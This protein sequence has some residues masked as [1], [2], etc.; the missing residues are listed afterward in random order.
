MVAFLL[1]MMMVS[2]LAD[3]SG[4]LESGQSASVKVPAGDTERVVSVLVSVDAPSTLKAGAVEVRLTMGDQTLSKTL[5]VGDPDVAW[6]VRQPKGEAGEVRLEAEKGLGESV[7]YV[8]KA[9]DVGP[10]AEDG[11][12]FESEPNDSPETADRLT[13]GQ[14]V[15]GLADD[16]AYLPR[17]ETPTEAEKTAG[18]DWYRLDFQGEK[19]ALVY[20]GLEYVDRDV[21]PDVRIF[22]LKDGKP[23]EYTEGIDPQSL[24][25]E[26]P[27]RPGANKFTTRV[28]KKDT[29]Y[30]LVDACQPDYQLRTWTYPVPPYLEK[31]QEG[32]EEV[33]KA[34]RLAIRSA[35]DFQVA[36]GDSWHANTP[37]QG[38]PM[39]RVANPHQ[40]TSTC[41]GCH[42]T[43]F[44]TQSS[45]EAVANGYK[46]GQ[47]FAFRFL[48]DRL[49]NN[50]VP[51]SGHSEAL[52]ARM[53]PAP[54]NVMGRLSTIVMDGENLITGA[55]TRH[56]NMHRGVAEFLGMY[57]N[58]RTTIPPDE[59]NGNNPV[60]RY[61]VASDAWKQLEEIHRRTNEAR[62]AQTRDVVANLIGTDEPKNTRDLAQQTIG[63]CRI[64]K[65]R[66]AKQIEANVQK[67][68]ELQRPDGHWSVK[69][70]PK[71][72]ITVMQT[73]ESLYALSLAGL[74]VDHPA[75]QK[76]VRAL[77]TSQGRFGGWLDPNPYEQFRTPFRETQWALMALARYYPGP[78][79]SGWDGPLGP[80]P[81]RLRTDSASHLVRD[82]ERVWDSPDTTLMAELIASL[83]HE[84]PVVRLAAT[85]A[86]S[87]VGDRGAVSALIA[88]LGD[89]SKVVRRGA[90]EAL[91]SIGDRMNAD[92]KPSETLDQVHFVAA[93][94][95]ALESPDDRTRR[96]ATRVFTAHF[97]DLSQE[98]E[99]ADVLLKTIDDSD[100][101]VAMQSVKGLWRWW[102]WQADPGL[103]NRIEDTLIASL[104]Q[105]RHPWVR[106]NVIEALYIIGDENIRYLF[107]SW[108]PSLAKKS[109][110]DEAIK[111]Q[112]ETVNRIGGKYV[113]VLKNGN[114]LQREGVLKALSEF[115]ERPA[116]TGGRVG[117]DIEPMVFYDDALPEVSESLIAQMS[118]PDASIRRLALQG[119]M[120]LKGYRDEALAR[121]VLARRG[122]ESE[123]VRRW[124]ESMSG[125]F[126]VSVRK[127]EADADL[128]S[129]VEGLMASDR[130]EARSAALDILGR[131]GPVAGSD[132]S[133][134]VLK[135]LEDETGLVRAEALDA[136]R[137]FPK[138]RGEKPVHQRILNAIHDDDADARLSAV[139]LALDYPGLVTDR[140][141]RSALEETAPKHRSALLEAIA[142]SK[143]YAKDLRLIG[144]VSEALE[145]ED[146]GVRERALQAIQ[147]HPDLV[148]NPAVEESLRE[149]TRSDNVRQKEIAT[150]LLKSKGRSSGSV[151]AADVLD[152]AYFQAKVLPVFETIAEDG[153]N[154][155]ECHKSHTILKMVG[156]G[157]GDRWTPDRVRA[158]YRS[159][160]RVVNLQSPTESL[161][162]RKPTWE[163]A[164][165]AEA[166]TDPSVH[167]HAGGVRFEPGSDEY[168][169]ILDWINGARLKPASAGADA[170]P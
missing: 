98:T 81:S 53:I 27:P 23:V 69:Y 155:M 112:H 130:P 139:K 66:Y 28:L 26:R 122:D 47:P 143:T 32:A 89:E 148:T 50:P 146:R 72:P 7:R 68:L 15:Y 110:R 109:D 48:I 14:S 45:L 145:D 134:L 121:S 108:I 170:A 58:G 96:G 35:M 9:V 157:K 63:M 61:K 19:P 38:H 167:A 70:D 84:V 127:G 150:A 64:D 82:L 136:L 168:Q 40:E 8:V 13:I 113:Q 147:A 43:H 154:C 59:S 29:Y 94:T 44:T 158:N 76:G 21:P 106:R 163:A 152:L 126:P 57:Y 166:Q 91:R 149:V 97:R 10:D 5:H 37:R 161:I 49:A 104:S 142:K 33:A 39:D 11:V 124:A 31:G 116:V 137:V 169:A 54:A 60:S 46:P 86:L 79:T 93:V 18:Q 118:D 159:A 128:L 73:G 88:R 65:E 51:F 151:S 12:A 22:T 125:S 165:E 24:Q 30:V 62:Y 42:A 3:G 131:W 102:Y 132:R 164:D 141:L 103:R 83:G 92:G 120:T 117:N 20:F 2:R 67:L 123:E 114:K 56:D 41:L 4:A 162:L 160:L 115:H 36:A 90:A 138:L 140:T 17:G 78:G 55:Q 153:Q 144:V 99:L 80:R 71:Y 34:A 1:S 95:A 52:W 107:G 135:G 105:P 16:R 100:P 77:L 75:V 119:L 74:K 111:A 25:R 156:P 129:V 6:M 85:Q 101:V 133:N 87:R